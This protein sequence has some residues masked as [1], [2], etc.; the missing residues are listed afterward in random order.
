VSEQQSTN[1]GLHLGM[2]L[3]KVRVSRSS[4]IIGINELI[5]L[6]AT[7]LV[8]VLV[9]ISYLYFL[10]PARA[11]LQTARNEKARLDGLLSNYRSEV[12]E[13][14]TTES[15]IRKITESLDAFESEQL[16]NRTQ[17]RMDLYGELNQ[18]INKNSLRNTAGPT[19]IPLDPLGNKNSAPS[20]RSTNNKWQSI[21]PGIAISV[22]VEGQYANLREFIHDIEAS[23]LFVIIN[24]IELERAT[25]TQFGGSSEEGTPRSALVSLRLDMATYFQ[26]YSGN[27][28]DKPQG[29]N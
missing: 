3:K 9:V 13:E 10:L 8:V 27:A 16:F 19:Y 12:Q 29:S 6:A 24:A 11:Q 18:L 23:K 15:T 20:S 21:Y 25:Q 28:D 7:A 1:H 2:R 14:Q 26:R 5:A 4:S 17:G 22:T